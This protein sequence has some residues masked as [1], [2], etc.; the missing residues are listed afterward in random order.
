MR[1]VNE[2]DVPSLVE[3]YAGQ[4]DNVVVRFI[5]YMPF[6]GV[7]RT[8]HHVPVAEL[9]ARL[10]RRYTLVP[11]DDARGGGPSRNVR[12][13]ETGQVVGFI[14]PITE[15]F[16]EACNRLRL[17]ADGHLRTCLSREAQPSL[18]DVLR[19]G[20]TDA[21]IELALR[22]R[23]WSKVAGHEAHLGVRDFEGVMTSVGG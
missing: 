6:D 12:L 13:R 22:G 14:S 10:A 17:Q 15:H 8:R 11:T 7:D 3:R 2:D 5:E 23:V 19:A 4:P 20:A 1:G 16:C 21:E 9:H 18:R